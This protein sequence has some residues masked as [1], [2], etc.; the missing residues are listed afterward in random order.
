[1]ETESREIRIDVPGQ[2]Q[3]VSALHLAPRESRFMLA[4]AHG[5]GA[6]MR[7]PFMEDLARAL[8][9]GGVATLRYQFPYMEQRARRPDSPAV[10]TATVRAACA[11]AVEH[12]GGVP[13]F[14]GG[15]SFGGRMTTTAASE[16]PL[17]GVTGIVLFGFPLHP[18]NRPAVSRAGH[19]SQVAFPML[20]LQGTRDELADLALIRETCGTLGP[21]ATLHVVEGADHSFHVLKRSGRT[22]VEV[23]DELVTTFADWAARH[24]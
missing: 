24:R 1:V 2:S 14:A 3:P 16:E 21:Q 12:A 22:D 15:K 11:S 9:A 19:L 23:L 4:L 5:A 17:A 8:A 6:G 7:H 10:A 13:V 20:F 18:P